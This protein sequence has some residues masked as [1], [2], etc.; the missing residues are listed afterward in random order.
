VSRAGA[1]VLGLLLA[2]GPAAADDAPLTAAALGLKGQAV[3]KHFSYFRETPTDN[4]HFRE[5]GVLLLEWDRRLAPWSDLRLVLEARADD[6]EYARGVTVQVPETSERRSWVGL[7][8]AVLAARRGPVE[9]TVGKQIFAWGTADAFNPTDLLNPYDYLDVLDNDKLGIWSAAARVTAGPTSLVFVVVP[10]FTPSRTPIPGSRWNPPP[11]PGSIVDGREVPGRHVDNVQYAAR[12]RTTV[13][14]WDLSVSYY[15]GF[16]DLPEIRQDAVAVA[17]GIVAPR[18]TP[19]FPRIK[20]PGADVSTAIGPFELHAEG[21]F[22]LVDADGRQ[23]T[24]Q[25]IAGLNYAWDVNARWL[26][27]VSVIAEYARETVLATRR[28]SGIIETPSLGPGAF[29]D[30]VAGRVTLKLTEDT[31]VR[32]TALLDLVRDPGHYAQARVVHKVTDWL[33][34]EG[35]LDF[36]AGDRDTFWGRFRDNDRFFFLARYYF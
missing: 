24:F 2:A 27:Q 3:V 16:D 6:D 10:F 11:P 13:R 14:G 34:V 28:H 20:V 26:Q 19:V 32:L 9:V 33:H 7:K 23:D 29:R 30:A 35:G 12:L 25:G 22:R 36:L 15:D 18:F 4:R 21:A 17:P 8:E 31:Q 5:E 1:A